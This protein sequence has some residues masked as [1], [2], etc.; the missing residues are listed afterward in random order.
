MLSKARSAGPAPNKLSPDWG[1]GE[2]STLGHPVLLH[3]TRAS[4]T[5]CEE[6]GRKGLKGGL[7]A[8]PHC[9][10]SPDEVG[11]G[12]HPYAFHRASLAAGRARQSRL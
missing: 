11:Y 12:S 2:G 4:K 5:G 1:T 7:L 8:Q 9:F 6:A 3:S 10:G